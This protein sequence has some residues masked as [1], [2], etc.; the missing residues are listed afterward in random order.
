[1]G[2]LHEIGV[3]VDTCVF[4]FIFKGDTRGSI[5]LN[6]ITGRNGYL[7]FMT[8]AELYYWA[9]S[10]KWGTRRTQNLEQAIGTYTIIHSND[11]VTRYWAYIR[12]SCRESGFTINNADAW[13]AAC[14]L[15][16]DLPLITNNA[17]DYS[18]VPALKLYGPHE[19]GIRLLSSPS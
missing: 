10:R 2:L 11:T 9:Q 8:V 13:Q 19:G 4:S 16:Y 1:M 6:F 12:N 17:K 3:I 14:A 5:F 18:S 15:A 7:S